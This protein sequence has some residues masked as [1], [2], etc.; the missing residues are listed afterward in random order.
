M[1]AVRADM[2]SEDDGAEDSGSGC[3]EIEAGTREWVKYGWRPP[4]G[5]QAVRE[6]VRWK[7]AS[8]S[9]QKEICRTYG[10]R[11]FLR[12]LPSAYALG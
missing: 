10:A 6:A 3:E 2:V 1:A 5:G 11:A 8:T 7:S 12:C 4:E 9:L